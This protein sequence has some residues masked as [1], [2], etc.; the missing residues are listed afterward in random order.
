MT[1]PSRSA[2]L[3]VEAEPTPAGSPLTPERKLVNE[4][5]KRSQLA[6]S[7]RESPRKRAPQS[8]RICGLGHPAPQT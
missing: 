6:A 7:D 8:H 2:S 1:S 3:Y 5:V 4:G